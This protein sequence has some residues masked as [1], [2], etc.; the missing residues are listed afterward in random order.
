MTF[1]STSQKAVGSVTI[2][3]IIL[4][5]LQIIQEGLQRKDHLMSK[6]SRMGALLLWAVAPVSLAFVVKG[7]DLL[8]K[9]HGLYR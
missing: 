5:H 8:A 6:V 4:R 2:K 3:V 9:T 7:G 1:Q